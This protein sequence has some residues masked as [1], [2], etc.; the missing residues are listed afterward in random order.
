MRLRSSC[1]RITTFVTDRLEAGARA[2]LRE[3]GVADDDVADVPGAGRVRA[4]AGGACAW[5][6]PGAWQRGRL[7]RLSDSRRDAALRLHR[8][9]GVARASCARRRTT[10]VPVRLRRADDEHGRRSAGARR[11]R[12]DQQGTRGRG[13]G[14]RDGARC[15]RGIDA[16]AADVTRRRPASG[17]RGG[18][19]SAVPLGSRPDVDPATALET[20]FAEH[21]PDADRAVREFADGA[22]AAGRRAIVETLDA[23]IEQHSEN[24]R[25]ERL[26]VDRSAHPADGDVGAAAQ[27]DTP[28]AVVLNEA[29]RA[30]A[31]VQHRRVREVRQRR[32]RRASRRHSGPG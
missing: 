12:R 26:A 19:C 29:H 10:G 9:G 31:P 4:A 27:P 11:R 21:Q 2:V 22:R 20:Y 17:A 3:A 18:A 14:D 25:L 5:R 13:R 32:A 23:L 7:P 8:A 1:R 15:T 6:S 30:G 28:P 16:A 24:W